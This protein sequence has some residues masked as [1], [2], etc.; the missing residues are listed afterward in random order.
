MQ[1]PRLSPIWPLGEPTRHPHQRDKCPTTWRAHGSRVHPTRQE[2]HR[3]IATAD[4]ASQPLH[5]PAISLVGN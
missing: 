1:S 2:N 5:G 4:F 3:D